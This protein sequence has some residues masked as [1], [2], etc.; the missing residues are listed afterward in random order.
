[1][2]QRDTIERTTLAILNRSY[3]INK[4]IFLKKNYKK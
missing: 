1:M 2:E 3:N 4:Y